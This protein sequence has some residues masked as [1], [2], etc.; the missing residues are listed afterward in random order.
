MMGEYW[1]IT[2]EP[3][4]ANLIEFIRNKPLGDYG[5]Q[6]QLSTGQRTLRQNSALHK[7]FAL[8]ADDL[9]ARGLD[10]R[11]VLKPGVAI[12]W[13][14][15]SVKT[16][17]WK[18]VQKAIIGEISTTKLKRDQVDAVYNALARHLGEKFGVM[19]DFPSLL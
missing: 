2:S 17:L 14:A 6:V 5:F 3:Q 18:P 9:N 19:V 11:A 13:T 4:R 10:Q 16:Y 8:L 12:E 1:H 15:D 7:Y